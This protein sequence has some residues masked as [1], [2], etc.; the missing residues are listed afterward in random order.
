[1]S[2]TALSVCSNYKAENTVCVSMTKIPYSEI[3]YE[4]VTKTEYLNGKSHDFNT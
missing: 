1:M 2:C 4:R 3:Q